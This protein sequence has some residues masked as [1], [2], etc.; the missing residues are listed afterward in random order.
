[1]SAFLKAFEYL[2]TNRQQ[3][4]LEA[5]PEWYNDTGYLNGLATRLDLHILAGAIAWAID[6]HE[7][8][9]IIIG[10]PMGN[11][12]LFERYTP[13][14]GQ[15]FVVVVNYPNVITEHL[16]GGHG[17]MSEE[18]LENLLGNDWQHYSDNFGYTMAEFWAQAQAAK[19]ITDDAPAQ[20][21]RDDSKELGKPLDRVPGQ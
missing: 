5:Q 4:R 18:R 15:P 1:M 17:A 21:T 9:V 6:K 13:N 10:T 7:R 11:I 19:E 14:K 3:S 12:V 20:N 2:S 16:V 8:R